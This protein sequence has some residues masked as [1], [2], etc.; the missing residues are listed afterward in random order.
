MS[1]M[2]KE[3]NAVYMKAFQESTAKTVKERMAAGESAVQTMRNPPKPEQKNLFTMAKK[4]VE[5][6]EQAIDEGVRQGSKQQ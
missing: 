6:I 5:T 4:R 2:T 1:S 3:E